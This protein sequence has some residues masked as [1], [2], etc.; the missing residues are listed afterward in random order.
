MNR[1]PISPDTHVL[2]DYGFAAVQA[3]APAVLG[4]RGVDQKLC[5]GFAAAVG[6]VNGLTDNRFGLKPLIPLRIHGKIEAPFVPA[7]VVLPWL[8]G[9]LKRPL[10]RKFFMLYFLAAAVSFLLTDFNARAQ[11]R[12]NPAVKSRPYRDALGRFVAS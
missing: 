9:S 12:R 2:L 6:L 11:R 10:A 3:L 1:K 8:A 4:L 7:L 5:H